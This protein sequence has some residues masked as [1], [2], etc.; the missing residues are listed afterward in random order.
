[1]ICPVGKKR[2][3]AFVRI[4][5]EEVKDGAA[6]QHVHNVEEGCTEVYLEII[7]HLQNSQ[8]HNKYFEQIMEE[9]ICYFLCTVPAKGTI[10]PP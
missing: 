4:G 8:V 5:D 10:V 6:E 2:I 1:L 7:F 9:N 3:V